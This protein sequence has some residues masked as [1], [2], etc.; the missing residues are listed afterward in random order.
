MSVQAEDNEVDERTTLLANSP[1][2]SYPL[3]VEPKAKHRFRGKLSSVRNV[4]VFCNDWILIINVDLKGL[5][6]RD[7][8]LVI[9]SVLQINSHEHGREATLSTV[10]IYH[11]LCMMLICVFTTCS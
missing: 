3:R 6:W 8:T 1:S 4:T 10:Q 5:N 7:W 11:G 2:G 9:V